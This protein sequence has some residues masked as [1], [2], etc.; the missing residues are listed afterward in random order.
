MDIDS[1]MMAVTGTL[2]TRSVHM[3]AEAAVHNVLVLQKDSDTE[4]FGVQVNPH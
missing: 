3:T 4:G 1:G 2:Q